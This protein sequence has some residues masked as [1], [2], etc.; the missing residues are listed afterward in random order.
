MATRTVIPSSRVWSKVGYS[1]AVRTGDLI[2]VAGTSP[3]GPDGK[4]MYP[5]DPYRQAKYVF[6]VILKAVRALGGADTD[7]VRTRVFVTDITKWE[8]AGRAHFEAFGDAPPASAFYEVSALLHPDLTIEVEA[9]A[10]IGSGAS[11]ESIEVTDWIDDE[12]SA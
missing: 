4:I 1:R 7:V 8:E 5:G 12:P 3:S 11:S 10:I 6:D 2:E 9:T